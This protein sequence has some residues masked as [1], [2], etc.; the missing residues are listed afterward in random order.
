M[1]RAAAFRIGCSGWQYK[2]WKGEFYPADLPARDWLEYYARH[3]DTVEVNNTFYRL[4]GEGVFESWRAR[5]PP[6][7]LFAVKASRFLTHMKKLNDPEEPIERLFSRAFELGGKLGPV[8]YQLPRQMP[9][10]IERLEAFLEVLPPRVK[11]AIEFRNPDWYDEEVMRLLRKH[12]VALCLHDMTPSVAPRLLTARFTYIRFHG[13]S[14]RYDGAYPQG[15]LED[16]ADWL[17]SN[18]HQAFVYFNNDIGGHAPRD[19]RRLIELLASRQHLD[20]PG[21]DRHVP[22]PI[23]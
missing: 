13:A 1:A 16:W 21:M 11:H 22:L 9:R 15:V 3:F 7:F 23:G 19:A 4:P 20:R 12:N 18:G 14:G 10:N 2:H 5:T 17:A 6:G 8:L